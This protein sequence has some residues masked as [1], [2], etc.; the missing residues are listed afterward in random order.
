MRCICLTPI[1]K[2]SGFRSHQKW[3]VALLY[4]GS[5]YAT[6]AYFHMQK[7]RLGL[8][9]N[10]IFNQGIFLGGGGG[11]GVGAKLFRE[12]CV[13]LKKSWLRPCQM[14]QNNVFYV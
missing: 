2:L 6:L 10:Q 14:N 4:D 5:K 7:K 11:V 13:P 3:C 8:Q 12:L 1:T 9:R